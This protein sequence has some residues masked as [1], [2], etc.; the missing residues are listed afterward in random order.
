[1]SVKTN[2]LPAALLNAEPAVKSTG[3]ILVRYGLALVIGWIGVC[4]F[5]PY[6][7]HNIEPLVA[8]SPFMGWLYTVV[9]VQ[10]FSTM[11]GVLEIAT[12]LLIIAKPWFPAL[13]AFGSAVAVLLF[14]STLSFLFTTPGVGEPS[15]G[16][17]PLLSMTGQFLIKDVVLIG[18]AVLTLA[19]SIGAI[20]HGTAQSPK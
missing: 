4:K 1:M 14:A 17:F 16:G 2:T 8:N 20:V 11:L 3:W 5:Y 6:E 13:S 9:S 7:A 19:D 15:A 12:A 10:T 18:V